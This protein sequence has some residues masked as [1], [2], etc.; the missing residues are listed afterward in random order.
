MEEQVPQHRLVYRAP[1]RGVLLANDRKLS[2]TLKRVALQ[3]ELRPRP[4]LLIRRQLVEVALQ[5]QTRR[6][7]RYLISHLN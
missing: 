2:E 3:Y 7:L 1:L 5:R 4:R 6:L